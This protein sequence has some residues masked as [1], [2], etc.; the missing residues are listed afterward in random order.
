MKVLVTGGTGFVGRH[1]VRALIEKGALVKMLVR[2]TSSLEEFKNIGV[3][4]IQGDIT[5]RGPLDGIARDIDIVYH[6]AAMGHVSAISEA[7]YREFFEINVN[8]TQNLA[9]ECCHHRVNKFIH[10]SSTAAMGLI[11]KPL[12]DETVPC[13]P[14]TPY[15][16]SK[17]K[18]EELVQRYWKENGLPAVILRPCMIYGVGGGGEFLK[19]CR[20]IKKGFFPKI[21]RG[22]NLTPIV[23]VR[24]VVQ[25]AMQAKEK[26]K[27]GE[28]YLIASN[29]SYEMDEIRRLIAK[30]L[31]V[32]KPYPYVP[33]KVAIIGAYGLEM[34]AKLFKFVPVVTSRNI[35]STV[36]DRVFSISKARAE[37]GYLPKVDLEDGIKETIV[38]YKDNRY[39]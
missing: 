37:L 11:K 13:Q 32:V 7:A 34:M 39:V 28:I 18:S 33:Y 23:H 38:W 4:F 31:G 22:K 2:K 8:G 17:Y 9:K 27:P 26:G 16:R 21:G 3:E 29:M 19:F 35:E 12:V 20:L 5:D 10:F 24:D 1:L 25:A 36:T 14:A 15:Q 6:L 30:Y